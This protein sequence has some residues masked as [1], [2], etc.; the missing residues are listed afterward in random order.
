MSFNMHPED[1]EYK[2][3]NFVNEIKDDVVNFKPALKK[4]GM[5]QGGIILSFPV[6]YDAAQAGTYVV[7]FSTYVKIIEFGLVASAL[8]SFGVLSKG[9]HSGLDSLKKSVSTTIKRN[10]CLKR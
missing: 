2:F 8:I 5:L 1:A 10:L 6:I 3:G 7:P 9:T 4:L